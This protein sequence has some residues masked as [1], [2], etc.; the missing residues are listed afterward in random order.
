VGNSGH[1]HSRMGL[2]D[3]IFMTNFNPLK[4]ACALLHLSSAE[5]STKS[6]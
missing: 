3:K 5:C 1:W 6:I 4:S 2:H